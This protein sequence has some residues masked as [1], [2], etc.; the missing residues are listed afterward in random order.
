MVHQD[1]LGH[2][3]VQLPRQLEEG[4]AQALVVLEQ[5][6]ARLEGD[7]GGG[8]PG[9]KMVQQDGKSGVEEG[10]SKHYLDSLDSPVRR[11]FPIPPTCEVWSDR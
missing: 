5:A 2:T 6:H 8:E 10:T 11:S 1:I 3:A 7:K 9:R 4:L